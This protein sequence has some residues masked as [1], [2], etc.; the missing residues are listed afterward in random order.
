M[1]NRK[2]F[3][4]EYFMVLNSPFTK[5]LYIDFPPLLLWSSLSELSEMLY[6]RQQSSFCP[7]WNLTHNSQAVYLF[8][9]DITPLPG[10]CSQSRGIT[11]R[12]VATVSASNFRAVPQR[13]HPKREDNNKRKF[14]AL[15]K[16]LTI[17]G[18]SMEKFMT[19]DAPKSIEIC[20]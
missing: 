18:K 6:P 3:V 9:D 17:F 10:S 8:L 15:P 16:E 20:W 14:R 4:N 19:K 12:E 2:P 5:T 1:T 11:L 13:F 7:R